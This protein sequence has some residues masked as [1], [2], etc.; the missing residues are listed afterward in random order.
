MLFS[1]FGERVNSQ[2]IVN[3]YKSMCTTQPSWKHAVNSVCYI[4]RWKIVYSEWDEGASENE[5]F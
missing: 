2:S 1:Y 3:L 5:S 4:A